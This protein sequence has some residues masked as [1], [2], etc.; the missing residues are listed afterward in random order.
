MMEGRLT[1]QELL[2]TSLR[3]GTINPEFAPANST[4]M[5]MIDPDDNYVSCIAFDKPIYQRTHDQ[6]G[7]L[8]EMLAKHYERAKGPIIPF[9]R[10][11]G[12]S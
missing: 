10:N 1:N 8:A 4:V 5:I 3:N 9:G 7:F 6:G 2:L 12:A 11:S